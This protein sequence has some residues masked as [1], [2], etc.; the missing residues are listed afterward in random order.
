MITFQKSIAVKFNVNVLNYLT[1][2]SFSLNMFMHASGENMFE[3]SFYDLSFNR[4]K[5]E[6]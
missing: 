1:I 4:S 5:V 2:S 6:K 3:K